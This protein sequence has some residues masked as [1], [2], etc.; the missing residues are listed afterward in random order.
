MRAEGLGCGVWGVGNRGCWLTNSTAKLRVSG[1]Y[2]SPPES[3]RE[4][5]K[6]ARPK[7]CG[8]RQ[9]VRVPSVSTWVEGVGFRVEGLGF[10]V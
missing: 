2:V 10:R 7:T 3:E 9:R 1:P 6:V 5:L 4:M 8:A